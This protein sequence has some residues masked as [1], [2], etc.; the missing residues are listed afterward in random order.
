MTFAPYAMSMPQAWAGV[1]Q[2]V[3]Q[4]FPPP[5]ASVIRPP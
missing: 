1:E 2:G 3:Y 4:P 5:T